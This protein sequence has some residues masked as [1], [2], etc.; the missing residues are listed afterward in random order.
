MNK[1]FFDPKFSDGQVWANGADPDQTPFAIPSKSFGCITG[2]ETTLFKF[3]EDYSILFG[4]FMVNK[5]RDAA[6]DGNLSKQYLPKKLE[7]RK[8]HYLSVETLAK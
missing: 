1:W 7:P 3:E 8:I 4:I 2:W 5:V 6:V